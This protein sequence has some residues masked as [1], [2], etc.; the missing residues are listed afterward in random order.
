MSINAQLIDQRVEGIVERIG[1]RLQAEAKVRN[2]PDKLKSAAFVFLVAQT[3]MALDDDEAMDGLV[4]GGGDFGI[5]A[6]YV[7]A[8]DDGEFQVTLIQGKYKRTLDG[9]GTFPETGIE[10][11][12]GAVRTIFDPGTGYTANHR[13]TTR[14]E[15]LRSQIR[16]GLI[17]SVRVVL[18]NNGRKWNAACQQRIDGF[19]SGDQVS[20]DYAGPDELIGL[21]RKKKDV[22]TKVQLSGRALVEDYAFMRAL[23]GRM[24][25]SELARLFNEYGDILLDRNIRRYLGLTVRVNEQIAATLKDPAQRSKFYFY[26]NG[27]TI[28][29]SK[30]AHNNLAEKDWIVHVTGLQIVNGGQTSKTIQKI[31]EEIGPEIG[32]AQVLVRIYELPQED[33][34]LIQRITEATNSQSPVDLRDLRSNDARQKNLGD[35]IHLLGFTYRRQRFDIASGPTDITS[36]TAAEAILAIWRHRPHSAR[37]RTKDHFGKLYDLIFTADL[38]GSQV[39]AAVLLLRIAENKRKRP[40]EG[41]PDFLQ[42]GSRFIAMLMGKYLLEDLGVMLADLTHRNFAT[43]RNLIEGR[44]E[45]YFRRAL[46]RIDEALKVIFTGSEP[47]L[48]K[49]SATFRRSDLVEMLRDGLPITI[50]LPVLW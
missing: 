38:N 17:P 42:Y 34:E 39:V 7:G 45:E 50:D 48:Q 32:L 15:E 43:A 6:V 29:C 36:T 22:Q 12:I 41:S 14:V 5:D 44:G 10:K 33:H 20:W 21:L 2:D 31:Q 4:E 16:E 19:G 18:C 49:L 27:I 30:F 46:A 37:F 28:V 40:P 24:S 47:S 35:S 3:L 25:V 26:N 13:L 1:D 11:M 9:D 23:V 8:P